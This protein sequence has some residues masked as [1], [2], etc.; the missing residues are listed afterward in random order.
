MRYPAIRVLSRT[1]SRAHASLT[2][3]GSVAGLTGHLYDDLL[4]EF[5]RIVGNE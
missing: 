4:Y 2:E 3:Y 5:N 1:I